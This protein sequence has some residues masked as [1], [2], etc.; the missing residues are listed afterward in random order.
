MV[1]IQDFGS[2]IVSQ[3]TLALGR[4]NTLLIKVGVC[5]HLDE[6]RSSLSFETDIDKFLA[7]SI[8]EFARI[9]SLSISTYK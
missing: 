3:I 8:L 4:Q 9:L 7:I 1:D 5:Y 2:V 6:R